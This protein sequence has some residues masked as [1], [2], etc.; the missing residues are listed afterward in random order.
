[1]NYRADKTSER[2]TRI[3]GFLVDLKRVIISTSLLS[4]KENVK[5]HKGIDP[6]MIQSLV[7]INGKENDR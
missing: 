5:R 2:G 1:M 3:M 4:K 7:V 6:F